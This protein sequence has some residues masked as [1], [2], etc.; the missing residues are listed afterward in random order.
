MLFEIGR[1]IREERKRRRITQAQLAE[2]LGMSRAT[3]S[4][5]ENGVI[6]DIG[7]RKVIRILEVLELEIRIRQAGLPPT[8]EELQE[9]E[10]F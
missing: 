5:I 2:L 9:E 6:Q 4:Q 1:H 7:I 10:N 3:I 8:L